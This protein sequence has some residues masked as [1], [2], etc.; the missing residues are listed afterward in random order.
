MAGK[1]LGFCGNDSNTVGGYTSGRK[2]NLL[3]QKPLLG[4]TPRS[5][6]SPFSSRLKPPVQ[7][8]KNLTSNPCTHTAET[9]H[10]ELLVVVEQLQSGLMSRM[11]AMYQRIKGGL[12]ILQ[13]EDRLGRCLHTA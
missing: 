13:K 7:T 2:G 6:L 5:F 3:L 9:G 10:G 12:G 8:P 11:S 1:A 4:M